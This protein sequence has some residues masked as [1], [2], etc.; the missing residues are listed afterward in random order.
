MKNIYTILFLV[1]CFSANA[2]IHIG[3]KRSISIPNLE[4][5]SEQSKRY[6]SRQDIYGGLFLNFQ[7]TK[8]QSLQPEMRK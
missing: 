1:I 4:G 6:T 2:P 7:L 5:N 8:L 3:V